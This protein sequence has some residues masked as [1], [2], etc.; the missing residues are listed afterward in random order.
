MKPKLYEQA[1]IYHLS[2]MSAGKSHRE[3]RKHI[4]KRNRSHAVNIGSAIVAVVRKRLA[5]SII[6]SPMAGA[7]QQLVT[8]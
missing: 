1:D 5:I 3:I 6:V 7:R 4:L 2:K 8:K